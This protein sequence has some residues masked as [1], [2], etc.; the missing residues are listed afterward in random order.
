MTTLL[1]LPGSYSN[2]ANLERAAGMLKDQPAVLA[3][4]FVQPV[5]NAIEAQ[6]LATLTE[7]HHMRLGV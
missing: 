5:T 2:V 4:L 1:V 7:K 3:R 6:P